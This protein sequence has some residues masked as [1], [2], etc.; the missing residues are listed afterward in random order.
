MMP[1]IVSGLR[2]LVFQRPYHEQMI[3]QTVPLIKCTDDSDIDL[4]Y[5]R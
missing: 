3:T 5:I 2:F 4:T 1:I